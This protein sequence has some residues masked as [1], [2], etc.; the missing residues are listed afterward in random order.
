[1]EDLLPALPLLRQL[2]LFDNAQYSDR[3]IARRYA[4]RFGV[5]PVTAERYLTAMRA[6]G[7]VTPFKADHFAV[8][9]RRHPAE[10]WP[11]QWLAG[12]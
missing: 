5:E 8:L 10:L 9:I 12:A 11:D 2:R 4:D 7:W 1:M 6:S 3:E